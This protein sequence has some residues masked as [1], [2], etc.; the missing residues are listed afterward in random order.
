[1]SFITECPTHCNLHVCKSDWL[2]KIHIDLHAVIC[3]IIL[4]IRELYSLSRVGRP[5]KCVSLNQQQF[6]IQFYLIHCSKC[7][8]VFDILQR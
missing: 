7:Q 1:M 6:D 5:I 3:I 8:N 4:F 2:V